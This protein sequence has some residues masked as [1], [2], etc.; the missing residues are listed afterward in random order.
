MN[1]RSRGP[2]REGHRRSR[3]RTA[4]GGPGRRG[5]PTRPGCG[6]AKR[7][8]RQDEAAD[9]QSLRAHGPE[10][11]PLQQASRKPHGEH[12]RDGP[13]AIPLG[14][15]GDPERE[16]G[17]NQIGARPA[18][19]VAEQEE[20][21]G[22]E[23]EQHQRV[24]ET[25]GER[26]RGHRGHE[27]QCARGE[28]RRRPRAPEPQ[29][30]RVDRDAGE[31][32]VRVHDQ[33][34]EEV[35][36]PWKN[37]RQ[38]EQVAVLRIVPR[39]DV[40]EEDVDLPEGAGLD[41]AGDV[42]QVEVEDVDRKRRLR[43]VL[44]QRR[45]DQREQE[46]EREPGDG[47]AEA[48]A[49][50]FA[51]RFVSLGGHGVTAAGERPR[52][53]DPGDRREQHGE[54]GEDPEHERQ[55]VD[56]EDADRRHEA[57][58]EHTL[59]AAQVREAL[60]GDPGGPA[61]G[62]RQHRGEEREPLDVVARGHAG[63]LA[64]PRFSQRAFGGTRLPSPSRH[65]RSQSGPDRERA[66]T[67]RRLALAGQLRARHAGPPPLRARDRGDDEARSPPH[68]DEH[69]TDR[70]ALRLGRICDRGARARRDRRVRR[71]A[72]WQH[73]GGGDHAPAARGH[74]S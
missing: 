62:A 15:E 54:A 34:G 17:E 52:H 43:Q 57:E 42:R 9:D 66:Q 60:Q 13:H 65:V 5:C 40:G 74:R 53:Q 37:R 69:G 27:E 21:P 4:P 33:V 71:L 3:C 49:R 25:G 55:Q 23:A 30:E 39:G 26:R 28:D 47:G 19:A 59:G 68:A 22:G 8:R 29:N 48:S 70:G 58:G 61:E 20:D 35:V 41:P 32:P 73:D 10:I 12:D 18:G 56:R 2:R 44:A 11:P 1:P 64:R 51:G 45:R 7:P 24:H 6:R 38:E 36:V 31:R 72:R 14:P 50:G 63:R 67:R 46:P 16:P